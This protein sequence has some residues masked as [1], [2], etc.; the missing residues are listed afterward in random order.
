MR[1]HGLLTGFIL[2]AFVFTGIAQAQDVT[3]FSRKRP[4]LE[5]RYGIQI[6]G[7]LGNYA[8]DDLNIYRANNDHATV[9]NSTEAANG[10]SWGVAALYRSHKNFRWTIGYARLGQDQAYGA[11]ISSDD[12]SSQLN[13]YTVSGS[14]FYLMPS[15]MIRFGEIINLNL[16]LGPTIVSATVDRRSTAQTSI[17]NS[18]GRGLGFRAAAGLEILLL[19]SLGI[20]LGGGYRFANVEELRYFDRNNVEQVFYWFDTGNRVVTADFSGIFFEGG[21]RYYFKPATGW[22]KM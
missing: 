4:H 6:T 9:G 17:Y 21:I 19:K 22:F 5:R 11:W 15:Y 10:A 12:G 8:M 1:R 18:K 16:G 2:G 7:G 3:V 14:E 13:E 20:H